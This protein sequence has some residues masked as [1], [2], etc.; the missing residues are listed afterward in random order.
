M[1]LHNPPLWSLFLGSCKSSLNCPE[2]A[3]SMMVSRT[4]S[5]ACQP[6]AASPSPFSLVLSILFCRTTP[7]V[8]ITSPSSL[9]P[10]RDLYEATGFSKE[11]VDILLAL[12]G[13][14]TQKRYA[15]PGK[16][17][18]HWCSHWSV[19]PIS[20]PVTEV[21]AFL[22]SLVTPRDLECQ[23]IQYR[24]KGLQHLHARKMR[25]VCV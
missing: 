21:L 15:G 13:T 5:D 1:N 10:I 2:L 12:W 22:T 14:P 3:Q 16:I 18:V 23:T 25:V 8:A 4:A 17:L 7:P 11:V 19:C 20:A 6:T 24:S 9:S